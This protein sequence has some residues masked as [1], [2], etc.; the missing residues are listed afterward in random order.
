MKKNK[1][2]IAIV[3]IISIMFILPSLVLALTGQT[4]GT[5]GQLGQAASVTAPNVDYTFCANENGHC[6]FSGTKNVAF[7]ANGFFN[8][9]K[10]VTGGIDC[11]VSNFGDPIYGTAKACFYVTPISNMLTGS[12][13][14]I[15]DTTA[16]LSGS[17]NPGGASA[18]G[19]FRY[20]DV[21]PGNVSPVFCGDNFGSDMIATNE[22]QLGA[23]YSPITF[24][25][26]I[27]NLT[28]NTTYYYCAIASNKNQID[29]DAPIKFFTTNLAGDNSQ[30]SSGSISTNPALVVNSSK[31]YL[32]G[33]YNSNY[34]S[35]TWFE[36]RKKT[37]ISSSSI[38]TTA[39]NTASLTN[40]NLGISNISNN[41]IAK[42]IS[43]NFLGSGSIAQNL[44][45][46]GNIIVSPST[47]ISNPTNT[48]IGN[49]IK[50]GK[51]NH[52]ASGSNNISY[53]LTGLSSNSTYQYRAAI[54][55]FPSSSGTF[56]TAILSSQ[57][58][59]AYGDTLTFQPKEG[60]DTSPGNVSEDTNNNDSNN[61][62][63]NGNSNQTPHTL[64]E[65]ITPNKLY[66]VGYHEGIE[67]VL[68]RQIVDNTNLAKA[69]GYVEGKDLQSFAW[70]L[71]DTFAKAFGY[72]GT[73][74]KELRVSKPDI[75]AYELQYVDGK[76]TIYEY[77][78]SKVVNIQKYS[79]SL[80]SKYSYE[81][82]F[83]K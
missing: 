57:G 15:T 78:N 71:A 54:E 31:V 65:K 19:Y 22:K 20:S 80:R 82:Y 28:P 77:Y 3:G 73:N 81:Y 51:T 62:S 49:W 11:L 64:G 27:T 69:F 2:K 14:K 39:N 67:T 76:L 26:D 60:N 75:A 12:P 45:S 8:Y 46:S 24:N 25:T 55:S 74:G 37:N 42:D 59:I 1:Q 30:N 38:H 66:L 18:V 13:T 50:V 48:T 10:N 29:Y 4:T 83:K 72:V 68:Q 53:L 70:T 63:D 47:S 43:A 23:G 40:S 6:A 44:L 17:A 56:G 5:L 35:Q 79:S 58:Q 61:N 21:A 41:Q 16:T 34:P 7:G 32:N 9:K 52:N 33:F 36:Y